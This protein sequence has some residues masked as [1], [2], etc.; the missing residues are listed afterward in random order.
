[1]YMWKF[2]SFY[3]EQQ[4]ETLFSSL[5]KEKE[6]QGT[7]RL[8]FKRWAALGVSL[9]GKT[10]G[11]EEKEEDGRKSIF[12]RLPSLRVDAKEQNLLNVW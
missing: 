3:P 5:K 8:A 7:V 11:S 6:K 9:C 12:F 1:M 2:I 10:G 4:K